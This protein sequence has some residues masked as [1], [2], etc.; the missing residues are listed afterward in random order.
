M[1]KIIRFLLLIGLLIVVSIAIE[2]QAAAPSIKVL[3]VEGT[4][5]PIVADYI[6]RGISQAEDENAT[7]C[8]IELDT[9]GGLLGSTERIVKRIMN[10]DVPVI[11]YV[12]PK[13]AWA[14]SAGTFITLSAH[15]A[16]MTPGTTIGAAHPVAAGG[17]EIPE[18]QMK[19]IT[20]FS[21]KWMKTIAQERGRN[22]EEAQLA[23]TESK[24]FTDVDAL[25]YNLI[26]L[27]VDNLKSL[28]SQI[29]GWKVTLANGME[30]SIDTTGYETARNEMNI[31][32][33]FLHAISNPNI[34]YVLLSL[35]TLGII[36]EIYSPGTFFPGI[37]GAISLLLAFY[38]LGVLDA[39][40][41]G[42]LLILLAF[43]L[44]IA[45]VLTTT[46]GLL[47][48]GGITAL[49]LGSLILFPGGSP[50]FQVDP[51]LIA[52]VVIII[53]AFFAFAVD[54]IIRARR[55]QAYTGREELI[56]KTAIVKVA[57]EPEGTVF[58][59]GERWAAISE[60]GR[61]EPGE[62]VIITKVDGLQ[63]YVTKKE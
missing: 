13:G 57:L 52:T 16:A 53:A 43:G 9:P 23:V 19:K 25:N 33:R 41:G 6:D 20:E 26:D 40:W 14:A 47:T 28:I 39:Y 10:A 18:E 44:F 22:V 36:A 8:I 59:K 46:F 27:R 49:V 45:E 35:G 24:S 54:R 7:A 30:V 4:I 5:V 48:A 29:N 3:R 51:W 1:S 50:L 37:I 34:A 63:L 58:F 42:I 56:G 31:V 2:V 17:E 38:S 15:I 21:A 61:V 55:R 62:K 60:K 12:S 11:V 32:E